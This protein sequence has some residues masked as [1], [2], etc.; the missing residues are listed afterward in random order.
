MFFT[1]GDDSRVGAV[2]KHMDVGVRSKV[3]M[4]AEG[5]VLEARIGFEGVVPKG[6]GGEG[7]S[8]IFSMIVR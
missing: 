6:K 7:G 1:N 8:D 4:G 3:A 5:Y 2:T